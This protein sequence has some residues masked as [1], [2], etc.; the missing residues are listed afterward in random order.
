V[1]HKGGTTYG[2][3]VEGDGGSLAY[4]PDHAPTSLGG[5]MDGLGERHDAAL[6]LCANVDLLIH[7]AQH[8][9]KEFPMLAFLG[10]ATIDYAVALAEEADVGTLCLFHHAPNR[11]DDEIDEIVRD[12]SG[13]LSV[14]AAAEGT[15]VELSG[16]RPAVAEASS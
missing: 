16:A 4:L 14:M 11:T 2:I 7:D 8:T 9:A 5:G 12:L 1:P 3:R 13:E 6:K 10:H 15:V